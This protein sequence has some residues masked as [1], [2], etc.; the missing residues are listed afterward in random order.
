MRSQTRV[1]EAARVEDGGQTK[2]M[3]LAMK[4]NGKRA[5]CPRYRLE[6]ERKREGVCGRGREGEEGGSQ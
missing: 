1:L 2:E 4:G 5:G 6:T 3:S